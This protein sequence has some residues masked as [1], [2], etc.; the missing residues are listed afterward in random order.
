MNPNRPRRRGQWGRSSSRPG[1]K[2]LR[3]ATP[4]RRAYGAVASRLSKIEHGNTEKIERYT[5]HLLGGIEDY[6]VAGQTAARWVGS[7]AA[8]YGLSGRLDAGQMTA[9]LNGVDPARLDEVSADTPAEDMP[10]VV[11]SANREIAGWEFSIAPDKTFSAMWAISDARTQSEMLKIHRA[12]VQAL[13]RVLDTSAFVRRG[14]NG[15]VWQIAAGLLTCAVTHTTSRENDPQLHDHILIANIARAPDGKWL[16]ID[17]QLF[18][19]T[20]QFG[21][22]MYGK[23]LRWLTLQRL[24]LN[25]TG[26]DEAGHRHIVGVPNDLAELWAE[27]SRQIKDFMDDHPEFSQDRASSI[28]R[29]DKDQRETFVQKVRRW[30]DRALEASPAFARTAIKGLFAPGQRGPDGAWHARVV[31][32]GERRALLERAAKEITARVAAWDRIEALQTIAEITPDQ[33]PWE[34]I[35]ALATELL[36]SDLVVDLGIPA[37]GGLDSSRPGGNRYATVEL[38]QLEDDIARFFVGGASQIARLDADMAVCRQMRFGDTAETSLDGEQLAAA[39]AIAGGGQGHLLSGA[40]GTGKTYALQ[41][42]ARLAQQRGVRIEAMAPAQSAAEELG[43]H[44]G[45]DGVNVDRRL[46]DPLSL[47][48]GGWWIVDEA[49]MLP[50]HQLHRLV[51]A[52]RQSGAKLILVGDPYQ[53]GAVKG[54]EGMFRTLAGDGGVAHHELHEVRRFAHDWEQEASKL[55]RAGVEGIIDTYAAHG[56]IRGTGN[57]PERHYEQRLIEAIRAVSQTAVERIQGGHE[58]AVTAGSNQVVIAINK[59]IQQSLVPDRE[60]HRFSAGNETIDIGVGD[61]IITRINDFTIRTTSNAP[62]ING[63]AWTVQS[64]QPNGDLRLSSVKRGGNV[65]LPAKYIA[66]QGSIQLGWAST[67]HIAQGRTADEGITLIDE[68]TDLELLYVG[69]TRGRNTNLIFGLGTDEEVLETAK[70]AARKVRAKLSATEVE[71]VSHASDVTCERHPASRGPHPAPTRITSPVQRPPDRPPAPRST[72]RSRVS[73]PP[74]R[75]AHPN[76]PTQRTAALR[77]GL[78]GRSD[79]TDPEPLD[80]RRPVD[81]A[82]DYPYAPGPDEDRIDLIALADAHPSPITAPPTTASPALA[83]DPSTTATTAQPPSASDSGGPRPPRKPHDGPLVV[84]QLVAA[85]IE[86]LGKQADEEYLLSLAT[87]HPGPI[88]ALLKSAPEQSSAT[89]TTA[90]PTPRTLSELVKRAKKELSH[91]SSS[92]FDKARHNIRE[93][94]NDPTVIAQLWETLQV[95]DEDNA[96]RGLQAPTPP[97][98]T[99]DSPQ[100]SGP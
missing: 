83:P 54:A 30:R 95:I 40:A 42:V 41:A 72:R 10:P 24:G 37:A 64:I 55:L 67:V 73:R 63:K 74:T 35:E 87:A 96:A 29:A 28:T 99:I 33:T 3:S 27:R 44:V 18:Y 100:H 70:T 77:S 9:M 22:T 68:T 92:D 34:D 90:K 65:I 85:A 59:L 17:G 5:T 97:T 61:R 69:A 2:T 4:S 52:A 16:T 71:E 91:T 75:P 48:T 98:P 12:A 58:V 21:V 93:D 8:S 86:R 88:A 32:L 66:Q 19:D 51:E 47:A 60:R 6:L 49:S 50:T 11:V 38:L 45:V 7:A 80:R 15:R 81:A 25:W 36:A 79:A 78:P 20:L 53:L 26:P 56:R 14:R 84:P 82:S 89:R 1:R 46:R 62:I 31:P 23:T 39:C 76:Q 43:D 13:V 57:A 94:L